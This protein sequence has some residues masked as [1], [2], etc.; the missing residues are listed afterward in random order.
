LTIA[1]QFLIGRSIRFEWGLDDIPF[2]YALWLPLAALLCAAVLFALSSTRLG[3]RF[4]RWVQSIVFILVAGLLPLDWLAFGEHHP[5]G[6]GIPA[7]AMLVCV[8]TVPF[9]P[10][11]TVLLGIGMTIGYM[12]ATLITPQFFGQNPALIVPEFPIFMLIV[13]IACCEIS[14][15]LYRSRYEQTCWRRQEQELQAQIAESEQK[16]RSLFENSSDGIFVYSDDAGGFLM[17]NKVLQEVLGRTLEE[18]RHTH[19]TEVIHPDDRPRIVAIHTARLRGEPAPTHYML[20]VLNA[21]TGATVICDMTIHR[22]EDSRFTTGAVRDVTQRVH[23][24]EE[25]RRLAQLPETN[26]FPVLRFDR[27][28]RPLYLNPVAQRFLADL[29]HP[30]KRITDF[31][32]P[33]FEEMIRR[34]IDTNTTIMDGRLEILDR[35]LSATYR[36]LP[37]SQQIYVWLIDVTERIRAEQR[38]H[39]YAAELEQANRDL[40]DAQ[41]QLVQSEKMAALG[42]LVAGVAHEINTPLGSIHANTDVARR[43]LNVVKDSL[44]EANVSVSSSKS[45]RFLRALMILEE[46][47]K[48]S[49]TASERIISFV[50]SL[51]NFARLDEAELKTVDIHEGLESTL[52]LVYHEYKSRIKIVRDYGQLPPITCFPNQMNQVFMNLIVNAI[53]AIPKEGT[54]TI[55]TRSQDQH[56]TVTISDTGVGIPPENLGRIFDPGFTTKGAGVGT[57]LGLSIVY[58][59]IQVHGGRID[60]ESEVGRGTSFVITCPVVVPNDPRG[61]IPRPAN[62]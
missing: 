8:A 30:D 25:V 34:L 33:D 17:A 56:F 31:L 14:A 52:T 51:R 55:T 5:S 40:R 59:I 44:P 27:E 16:Y 2:T 49:T 28:G 42:S 22:A 54:I 62:S 18:L 57:G 3:V 41:I 36:P 21:K 32:P 10:W 48:T 7:V 11:H 53:H 23:L 6:Y 38:A 12:L 46:A 50:R 4:G 47:N 29:G 60:V 1:A 9:R 61:E 15:L 20:K 26:P 58:K 43:A 45:G 35:V 13:T 39:L 37:E 24:E 19:F